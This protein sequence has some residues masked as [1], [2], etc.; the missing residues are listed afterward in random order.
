MYARTTI[1]QVSKNMPRTLG[2]CFLHASQI[3][4]I[5]ELD[6]PLIELPR[7]EIGKSPACR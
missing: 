7:P 3:H 1:A 5:V 6:E 4:R 2:E